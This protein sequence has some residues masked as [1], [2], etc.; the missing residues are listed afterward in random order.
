MKVD[1]EERRSPRCDAS[2]DNCQREERWLGDFVNDLGPISLSSD[3][4]PS[5]RPGEMWFQ[6]EGP[7]PRDETAHRHREIGI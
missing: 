1:K 5:V 2:G 3:E 6:N 4:I 7:P